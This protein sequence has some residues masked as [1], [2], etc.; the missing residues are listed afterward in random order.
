MVRLKATKTSL[1]RLVAEYVDNLPPMRSGT[2]FIKY[3]RRPDYAMDWITPEWDT[4]HAFFS[5]CMGHALLSIEIKDG[6]TGKTV[7]RK[8]YD[9]DPQDLRERG[10]V[11]EF[12]TAAE[13][14]RL[15]RGGD[16]GGLSPAT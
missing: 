11:E 4:G 16:N 2:Q 8:V 9:L 6:E 3:P 5:T 15:E 7:S 1:Y 14:R 10:M 13:R 12:V